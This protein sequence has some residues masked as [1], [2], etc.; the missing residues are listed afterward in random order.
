M[1]VDGMFKDIFS[2]ILEMIFSIFIIFFG[3]YI[4]DGFDQS[5]YKIAQYYDNTKEV[6]LVYESN[7]DN[8]Y[9]GNEIVL[10]VHNISDKNNNKDVIFKLKKDIDIKNISINNILYNLNDIYI[11]NDEFYNYYLI[12]DAKLN[13]YETRVYFIDIESD[14]FIYDYEFI[15]EV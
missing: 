10:S 5:D 11:N 7:I 15:T 2:I 14:E 12:E 3:Y 8:G 6:Q 13:G 1:G 9:V 4:W